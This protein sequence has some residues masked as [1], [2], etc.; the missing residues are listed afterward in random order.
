MNSHHS[1]SLLT[2]LA[3]HIG[4]HVSMGFALQFIEAQDQIKDTVTDSCS[5]NNVCANW[6][7]W[8]REKNIHTDDSGI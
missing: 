7:D 4:W 6:R 5:L 1:K 2:K 8:S 3:G